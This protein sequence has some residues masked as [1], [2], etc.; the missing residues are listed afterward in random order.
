MR[1]VTHALLLTLAWSLYVGYPVCRV[2]TANDAP[3]RVSTTN[4][5]PSWLQ[6]CYRGSGGVAYL[7][8][9]Q[10]GDRRPPRWE[11]GLTARHPAP[12]PEADVQSLE[13]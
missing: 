4:D 5:A 6:I 1:V 10:G 12:P 13:S 11:S 3:Y 7:W 2:S 8:G 9:R